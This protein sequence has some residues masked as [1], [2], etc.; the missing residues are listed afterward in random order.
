MRACGKGC[1]S[2][3]GH[4]EIPARNLWR[5]GAYLMGTLATE[6]VMRT[7]LALCAFALSGTLIGACTYKSERVVTPAAAPVSASDV[8][9]SRGYP[10]GTPA[11]D[12][13]VQRE[14][15]LRR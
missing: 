13:C 3:C 1:L 5:G 11:Y 6:N 8:C 14:T 10:S 4:G 2:R 7:A 9:V 15:A 12:A